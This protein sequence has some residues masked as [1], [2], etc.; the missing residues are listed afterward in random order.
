[1]EAEIVEVKRVRNKG[2]YHKPMPEELLPLKTKYEEIH[3][4]N[5]RG[6]LPVQRET[7]VTTKL[8]DIDL[9][10]PADFESM[11]Q[12]YAT[13]PEIDRITICDT[14]GIS[15]NTF[16]NLIKSPKYAE[17]WRV[18]K[19]AKSELLL[20][21][22]LEAAYAPYRALMDGENVPP[23]LIKAAQVLAN[24]CLSLAKIIDPEL[25]QGQQ[26]TGGAPIQIQVNTGINIPDD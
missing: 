16:E 5:V 15:L 8:R 17:T 14:F 26:S 25:S 13:N 21:N 7:L 20:R 11:M 6:Q 3:E 2:K 19:K 22:S 4:L 23:H 24:Q 10:D 12:R 18:V 1:M 9:I